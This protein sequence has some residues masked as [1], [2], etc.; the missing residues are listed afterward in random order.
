MPETG[1][2]SEGDREGVERAT[3]GYVAALNAHD[4]AAVCSLLAAGAVDQVRLP[5][6]R[7]ACS[8]SVGAS[9]GRGGQGGTPAWKRTTIHE[10]TAVS[11]GE[12]T[13]RVT[14]TVTHVFSDRNYPSIEEDVIYLRRGG[15]EWLIAKPS[16]SFYRAVGY[17]EPPLRAFT[18]P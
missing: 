2:L 17:P 5:V 18:A 11:V 4:G 9:I 12:D 3:R 14:A 7:G 8:E 10:I 1:S 16:G 6:E 15:D 13:A